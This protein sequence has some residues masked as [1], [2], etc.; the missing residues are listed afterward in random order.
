M[1]VL[2]VLLVVF[3]FLS[4][5]TN[6][7][8]PPTGHS[9]LQ[10]DEKNSGNGEEAPVEKTT[11][12][13][14]LNER[15][16]YDLL[17]TTLKLK[18][19]NRSENKLQEAERIAKLDSLVQTAGNTELSSGWVALTACINAQSCTDEFYVFMKIAAKQESKS[20]FF[21]K[22]DN[23]LDK[24]FRNVLELKFAAEKNNIVIRSKL[25]TETNSLI[26][27]SGAIEMKDVW[28]QL[29]ACSLN[30]D[31]YDRLLLLSVESYFERR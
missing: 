17:L 20:G 16:K 11:D 13:F 3:S 4:G 8:S 31:L 28:E 10:G 2:T 26:I 22:K 24:L 18:L 6:I 14:E 7:F 27:T 23:P 30:C 25:V 21:W 5:S 19:L 9:I 12:A 29:V 1:G 15:D